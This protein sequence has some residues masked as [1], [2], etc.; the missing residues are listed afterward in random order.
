[1]K[2]LSIKALLFIL[3]GG[4]AVLSL[5]FAVVMLFI[6]S[7]YE[8]NGVLFTVVCAFAALIPALLIA[9]AFLLTRRLSK[10][11]AFLAKCISDI[12]ETG[13]IFLDDYAYKQTK[14][15]NSRADEI[16]KISR[17]VGDMLAMFRDKIKSLN[18]VKDGDLT[19]KI[20]CRS[21]KDTVGSA[22]VKMTESLNIM[23]VDIQDA[24]NHVT[25]GSFKMNDDV[26]AL[27]EVTGE[28]AEEIGHLSEQI[29]RVAEQ[30]AH[31]SEMAAESS[32]LSLS[33][34]ELAERG[35]EQ[36]AQMTEAVNQINESSREIGKVIKIIDSIAFQTNILAL[37]AAVEAARAGD[38]GKGF[39]VVADEVRNLASKSAD[40]ARDTSAL[41]ANSLEK[42]ELGSQIAE[43]TAASLNEIVQR[44][45]ESTE[46]AV[47][48]ARSSESQAAAIADIDK[49]IEKINGTV[50]KN[51]HT[52]EESARDSK[53]ISEQSERLTE[54]IGRFK[55]KA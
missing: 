21:Q 50:Q 39:A 41:I 37:N 24:S 33:V 53:E 34:K 49:G 10:P 4:A 23:F 28:Q 16:G 40:A 46:L 1:M 30:T 38:A 9:S 3:L 36:M 31:S 35:G 32:E 6:L 13:N 42:A 45:T 27:A 7:H 48:I 26:L 11:L 18:A 54:F 14:I 5:V 2:K 15:L 55:I 17:S 51:S 29:G 20:N 8:N 25:Q 22:L 52:A 12:A 44:I 43:E 19:T 47:K